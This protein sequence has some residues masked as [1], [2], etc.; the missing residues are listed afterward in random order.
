[1]ELFGILCGA[2]TDFRNLA[3]M[4]TKLIAG[5]KYVLSVN[6]FYSIYFREKLYQHL[7]QNWNRNF[8]QLLSTMF[9]CLVLSKSLFRWLHR[10]VGLETFFAEG[11]E[12][13]QLKHDGQRNVDGVGLG[14]PGP[15][16]ELL[17]FVLEDHS[18]PLSFPD[19]LVGTVGFFPGLE[20]LH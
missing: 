12:E 16:P 14:G 10:V 4:P 3:L 11:E 5:E 6:E 2:T 8:Y 7:E 17:D 18:P 9:G 20:K 19:H 13:L 1:M 15:L